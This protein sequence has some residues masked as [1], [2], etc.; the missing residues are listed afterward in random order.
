MSGILDN[1]TRAIDA[2]FTLEGRRQLSRG[3]MRIEYVSFTDA[4]TYYKSDVHSGSS[5]AT[6]RIFL[7]ACHLP[8]DQ[9]TFEADDSGR[10]QPFKNGEGIQVRDG[11]IITYSF[12]A[13]SGSFDITGSLE[14]ATILSG[15]EFASTSETLI[16]ESLENFKRLQVIGTFDKL[17]ED[18]GF[19]VGNSNV[20]FVITD[21]RPIKSPSLRTANISSLDSLFSD[22]RLSNVKNFH[23]LPPVNKIH[24]TEID[25]ADQ[26]QTSRFMLGNYRPWGRTQLHALNYKQIKYELQYYEDLGYCRTI[27]FDPTSRDNRLV[28]QFFEKT[29]NQLRK[30]DVIDF[31]QHRTEDPTS[32]LAHIFFV[33]R[34]MNDDNNTNTF[35]H[36]FTLVFE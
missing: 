4:G 5:D 32:P 27:V 20:E 3:D 21:D 11:Q 25:K 9:I 7:E 35:I 36:L 24:D 26:R 17:F 16:A 10:L 13:P 31:G 19:G 34:I 30:L 23:Y 28:G 22:P 29:F 6:Q 2:M 8:Q 33:G 18:D 1:K 12:V 14:N 15:D